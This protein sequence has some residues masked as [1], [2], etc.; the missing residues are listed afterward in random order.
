M[1][2]R[3]IM[4]SLALAALFALPASAQQDTR[5]QGSQRDAEERARIDRERRIRDAQGDRT[6]PRDDRDIDVGGNQPGSAREPNRGGGEPGG[7]AVDRGVHEGGPID[8]GGP[9]GDTGMQGTGQDDR[10]GQSDL[11]AQRGGKTFEVGQKAPSLVFVDA[12][13]NVY[14]LA[15]YQSGPVV[16][17]WIEVDDGAQAQTDRTDGQQLMQLHDRYKAQGVTWFGVVSSREQ[18]MRVRDRYDFPILVDTDGRFSSEYGIS[19]SHV[20]VIDDEGKVAW[21]GAMAQP[22]GTGTQATGEVA[23]FSE[24]ERVLGDEA[25]AR[26]DRTLPA[27]AP[28]DGQDMN[29]RDDMNR[30]GV[31]PGTGA[32]TNRGVTPGTGNDMNRGGVTPGT[33]ADTNRGVTPGTGTTREGDTNRGQDDGQGQ[34]RSRIPQGGDDTNRTP[35]GGGPRGQ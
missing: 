31:T 22:Q 21:A 20:V 18:A 10:L 25:R 14:A 27:G 5:T 11:D 16:L 7:G 29:R 4:A 15:A 30:G 35:D 8:R 13:G 32:D 26:G 34:D 9:S 19:G 23:G 24:L 12:I 33:G 1:M 6:V 2:R 3:S 28:R 17:Q